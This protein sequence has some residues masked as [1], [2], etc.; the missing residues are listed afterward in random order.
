VR[1]P[2]TALF[3]DRRGVEAWA[4]AHTSFESL[5]LG[6][7]FE[8]VAR[9][10]IRRV[11]EQ[12]FGA[13]IVTVGTT[14]INDKDDRAAHELDIVALSPGTGPQ[15]RVIE[16]IGEGKLRQIHSEDL[17]RLERMGTALR[18]AHE[19][20]IVLASASGFSAQLIGQTATRP[21]VRLIGLEEIYS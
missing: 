3:E 6:P 12:Y 17:A 1:H 20:P 13:Q 18:G 21:E 10:H 15:H 19:V 9:E 5:V 8:H 2:R 11:G 16:A 7:H 14:V 4:D